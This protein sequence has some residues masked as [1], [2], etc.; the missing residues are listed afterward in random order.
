MKR[1][2]ILAVTTFVVVLP[3]VLLVFAISGDAAAGEAVF[4]SRCKMCHGADGAGNP[5]M[6]KVLSVEIPAMDSESVQKQTDTELKEAIAKGK[7]KM[8]AIRG[9]SDQDLANVI[10]FVRSLKKEE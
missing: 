7:G 2:V 1:F 4:R 8:A 6:A 5:A 10:A 9:L 3:L